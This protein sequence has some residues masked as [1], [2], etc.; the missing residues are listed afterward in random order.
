[1][2]FEEDL[3]ALEFIF[4]FDFEMDHEESELVLLCNLKGLML[5][6]AR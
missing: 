3:S 1:M 2:K 5:C 4:D 6:A